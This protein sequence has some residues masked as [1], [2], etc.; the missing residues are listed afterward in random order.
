MP[1]L[2]QIDGGRA[3]LLT[4]QISP[5]AAKNEIAGMYGDTLKIRVKA[6]PVDGRANLALRGFVAEM[7]GV[8]VKNVTMESGETNKRKIIKIA[9]VSYEEVAGVLGVWERMAYAPHNH[10]R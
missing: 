2:N 7:L 10:H 9:G 5:R 4:V 8:P 1:C 3:L 6:P